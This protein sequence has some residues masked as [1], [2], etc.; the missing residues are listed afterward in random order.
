[1]ESGARPHR[2]D[3]RACRALQI[4]KIDGETGSGLEGTSFPQLWA[5]KAEVLLEMDLYQPSRL[6]LSEAHLAFQVRGTRL[7]GR[8]RGGRHPS[9][10]RRLLGPGLH[11]AVLERPS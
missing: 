1:M 3:T 11:R 9:G 8:L 4:L 7:A 10:T 6:L 2:K 5:L